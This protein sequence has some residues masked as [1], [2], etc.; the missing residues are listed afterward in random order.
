MNSFYNTQPWLGFGRMESV[1]LAKN[2]GWDWISHL[3]GGKMTDG[4]WPKC[5]WRPR[6]T[7]RRTVIHGR[8]TLAWPVITTDT[9][10]SRHQ[11]YMLNSSAGYGYVVDL[12]VCRT[13][14]TC[15]APDH[16]GKKDE[17]LVGLHN[18][19]I[20][21]TPWSWVTDHWWT[22]QDGHCADQEYY[23]VK[24]VG[25]AG[26]AR[27]RVEC[28]QLHDDFVQC[29]FRYKSVCSLFT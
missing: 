26:L 18:L 14:T 16:H 6:T 23:F 28:K 2:A 29:A 11:A 20:I 21:D 22:Y 1:T 5:L 24:C 25:R 8:H 7:V 12:F 9:G 3:A 19:P 15:S 4:C 27:A 10:G 17:E 13:M